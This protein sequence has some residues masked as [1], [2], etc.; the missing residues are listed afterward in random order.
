MP[1]KLTCMLVIVTKWMDK[2]NHWQAENQYALVTTENGKCQSYLGLLWGCFTPRSGLLLCLTVSNL[3]C[4]RNQR[5]KIEVFN[6]PVSN[7]QILPVL[8][9]WHQPRKTLYPKTKRR[10]KH[11]YDSLLSHISPTDGINDPHIHHVHLSMITTLAAL[12]ALWLA[13]KQG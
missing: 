1:R 6:K 10:T 3:F 12:A 8:N 7:S 13:W 11:G 4:C 2:F 5:S 9:D